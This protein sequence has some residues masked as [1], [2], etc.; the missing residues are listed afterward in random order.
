[1]RCYAHV[2]VHMLVVLWGVLML[3][4]H[5]STRTGK[6][7]VSGAQEAGVISLCERHDKN[8]NGTEGETID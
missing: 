4:A 5:L 7:V 6:T 1:M 2:G 3:G 8:V